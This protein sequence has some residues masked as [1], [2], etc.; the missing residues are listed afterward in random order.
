VC[1]GTFKLTNTR[2]VKDRRSLPKMVF[3]FDE[4]SFESA[5]EFKSKWDPSEGY[6]LGCIEVATRAVEI[7]GSNDEETLA[8]QASIDDSPQ[9]DQ[10][11]EKLQEEGES[12]TIEE[13]MKKASAT[14]W[15]Y[16]RNGVTFVVTG[17]Q[18]ADSRLFVKRREFSKFNEF[19]ATMGLEEFDE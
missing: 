3:T 4:S 14:L 5:K 8:V 2:A 17:D 7:L 13:D 19:V 18:N 9:L 15:A 6:E 11:I 10:L 12:A 1:N 16:S